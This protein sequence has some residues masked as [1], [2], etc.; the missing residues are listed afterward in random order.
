M[1][2]LGGKFGNFLTIGCYLE[3]FILLIGCISLSFYWS[4]KTG[5][6]KINL[7]ALQR[8]LFASIIKLQ[9]KTFLPLFTL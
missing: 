6:S 5:S 8:F 2:R 4:F 9:R 7:G 1:V 3:V